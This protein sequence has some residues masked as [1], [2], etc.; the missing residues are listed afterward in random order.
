MSKRAITIAVLA[1]ILPGCA[2]NLEYMQRQ[3]AIESMLNSE[4]RTGPASAAY[5]PRGMGVGLPG[6]SSEAPTG[7]AA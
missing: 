2:N 6:R 3:P 4:P 5:G 7:P 1:L